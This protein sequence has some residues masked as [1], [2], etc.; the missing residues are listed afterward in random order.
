[1]KR[2]VT[3]II[4]AL[5]ATTSIF[6][7]KQ[8][9]VT[10]KGKN[11]SQIDSQIPAD[12]VIKQRNDSA[13]MITYTIDSNY[14]DYLQFKYSGN[15]LTC[16]AKNNSSN[17]RIKI[18]AITIYTNSA[19]SSATIN[20]SGNLFL[21]KAK[22]SNNVTL[23]INGSGDIVTGSLGTVKASV[24]GS[25]DLSIKS[26]DGSK[27]TFTIV[28][29]GDITLRDYVKASELAVKSNGSGD[30]KI[31]LVQAKVVTVITQGSGDV[32][33]SGTCNSASYSTNGSG[34]INCKNLK[35]TKVTAV[36]SGSGDISC[37]AANS[38]NATTSGAGD[39]TCY[40][41]PSTTTISGNK[42]SIKIK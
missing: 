24:S 36:I 15:K 26:I 14:R 3:L 38:I 37:Y 1:M 18:S 40:G 22:M 28:G 16:K 6:A 25:G 11:F 7:A 12:I 31:P 5:A 21:T 19:L 34:D 4:I 39:I 33:I 27:S 13:G 41:K 8:E 17:K 32:T 23:S 35:A 2:F 30:I 29:S 42:K 10:L 20:G 9:R